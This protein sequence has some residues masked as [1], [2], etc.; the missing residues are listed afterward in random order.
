[1]ENATTAHVEWASPTPPPRDFPPSDMAVIRSVGAM[2]S[3]EGWY[4]A[5]DGRQWSDPVPMRCRC[6]RC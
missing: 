1:M 3:W 6:G 2:R 4:W 5:W